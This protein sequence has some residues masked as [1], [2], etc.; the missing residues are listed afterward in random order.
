MEAT[1]TKIR[2]NGIDLFHE[3]NRVRRHHKLLLGPVATN[4]GR[5]DDPGGST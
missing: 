4:S 3:V 1:D 5:P 2:V